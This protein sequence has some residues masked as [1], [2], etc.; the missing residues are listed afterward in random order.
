VFLL[1]RLGNPD[2]WHPYKGGEKPMD[3]SYFNAVL[4]STSF[5]PYDPWF[6]GGYINYYYWGFVLVGVP[7]KWLGIIP[8]VAYNLILPTLFALLA[9]AAFSV[10]WNLLE[11]T[12]L[13]RQPDAGN[14]RRGLGLAGWAGIAAA[15]GVTVLGNLGTVRMIWHGIQRLAP[16]N[17]P[18]DMANF[19]TRIGWTVTGFFNLLRGS[20]LPYGWGDWYWIP[21]R[22]IPGEPITEFPAFTFLYADLHAH[23]IALPLTLL[24]LSWALSILIGRWGWKGWSQVLVSFV[25]GGLAIGALRTTNTWDWPTYLALGCVALLY[26]ALRYGETCCL[27]LPFSPLVRRLIAAAAAVAALFGLSTLLFLPFSQWFGQA[28]NA[29]DPWSGTHTPFWSYFTHWGLFLFVI[30]SW[31]AWESID[32]MASTPLSTLSKLRPYQFGLYGALLGLLVV[33]VFLLVRGVGIAW[34]VLPLAA[35]AGVLLLRPAMPDARR[36]VLFMVGTALVLTLFV[37]VAVLR[38]DIGRMNTVFKFYLQAW[39]LLAISAGAA[40]LWLLPAVASRWPAGWRNGWQAVL[41]VLVF[42]AGL[43]PLTAGSDKIRDRMSPAAPHTLNGM[44]YMSYSRYTQ[45]EREMDLSQDERAIRWMQENVPGSPVIVE[46]NT[47]EY[48]W[49]SRFTIYTGLPGVVGWNWHQRQQRAVTPDRWVTDRVQD[50]GDFYRTNERERALAFLQLY[51]VEYIVVGQL[52]RAVYTPPGIKKFELF[53][54]DLWQEVYR[55]GDTA[56]YQVAAAVLNGED[57][58]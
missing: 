35:W 49:G 45:N 40:L 5:P 58:D 11:S 31:M 55:D 24:A 52:E 17:V 13:T 51:Q 16:M 50:I 9:L 23:M 6:A 26:S 53:N 28:Y 21:S 54:G 30:A 38:G 4:K 37:E 3:F 2:L 1:V 56:I 33:M 27:N 18:F 46:A 15:L 57:Q 20:R 25:L 34:L 42:S 19:F 39:S 41:V 29:I 43:F 12:R 36:A 47:P 14:G 32:W 22:A 8:A 48:Q 10:G 7:V 44:T